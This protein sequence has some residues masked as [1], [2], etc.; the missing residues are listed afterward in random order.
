MLRTAAGFAGK[1]ERHVSKPENAPPGFEITDS[2][3]ERADS[4]FAKPFAKFARPFSSFEKPFSSFE[5]ADSKF[6]KL[7]SKFENGT[8]GPKTLFSHLQ[9]CVWSK[10]ATFWDAADW[11]GNRRDAEEKEMRAGLTFFSAPPRLRV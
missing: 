9:G 2:R 7:I 10:I 5:N 4:G 3:F 11:P 1:P 6:E 8:F